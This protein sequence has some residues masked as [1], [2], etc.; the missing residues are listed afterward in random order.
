MHFQLFQSSRLW[1]RE[2]PYA[3]TAQLRKMRTHTH[4]LTKIFR[5]CSDVGARRT[6][7]AHFEIERPAPG[8]I[9]TDGETHA[10]AALVE[11]SVRPRSLRVVVPA[12]A[13]AVSFVDDRAPAGFALQIP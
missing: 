10:T 4:A 8:L 9:H 13:R 11:V 2:I 3:S 5:Q 6:D 12:S 1:N 7:N